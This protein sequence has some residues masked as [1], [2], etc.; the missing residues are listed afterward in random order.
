VFL[1]YGVGGIGG[2]L[3]GGILGDLGN[4][5]LAFTICGISVLVAA[6][7]IL[8]VRPVSETQQTPRQKPSKTGRMAMSGH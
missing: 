4:F 2:P 6:A 8:G 1:A 3:L 5:P 7:I